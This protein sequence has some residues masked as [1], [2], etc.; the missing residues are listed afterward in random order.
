MTDGTEKPLERNVRTVCDLV[1]SSLGPF[2]TN[3]LVVEADGTVTT[4]SSGSEIVERLD[5]TNPT[6]S[7]LETAVADFSEQRGDGAATVVTLL[8][9]LL[10]EADR[11]TDQGCHPTIVERGYREALD[12]VNEYLDRHARPL[13]EFGTDAVARTALTGTRDPN[14]RAMVAEY[15]ADIVDDVT[16]SDRESVGRSVKVTSRIGGAQAET[17]L[18]SG[19]VLDLD[20]ASQTMP[21]SVE[22]GGV[23]VLSTTVDV[24]NVGATGS[25][26]ERRIRADSFETRDAIG[27]HERT[28]FRET[29][30]AAVDAGCRV[31]FTSMAVNERV[32]NRLA[33]RGI[34]A[35]PH[36]DEDD[37]GKIA[38]TTGATVIPSLDDVTAET[39]GA[40]DVNVRRHAGTDMVHVEGGTNPVYTLFC[41]APDPHAADE[42]EASV[43]R[44]LYAAASARDSDTVVPGGGAVAI[45]AAQAVKEYGRSVSGREQ[46]AV[47]AFADALTTVPRAL[48]QNGGMDGWEALVQLVVAHNEGRDAY[49]VDSVLGETRDVLSDDPLV[50]PTEQT[51]AAFTA[52]TDLAVRL[53]RIDEQVA[54]SDLGGDE[55]GVADA[56]VS[57]PGAGTR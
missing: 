12:V 1:E 21:R 22:R 19:V 46:L 43:E 36:V 32:V 23:A 47:T 52:A 20:P 13:G 38:R 31:I 33:N 53:V 14:T 9:G 56:G 48:A 41:R 15:I 6:V 50:D 29:L 45:G 4:T 51:R 30:S 11:L 35:V 24:P 18:V 49:G 3:K 44:A 16:D 34:L 57:G 55:N 37:L 54:A 27:E 5:V 17:Q 28:Q 39:L 25:T 2:G 26:S 42:F 40:G 8:G 10:R 7:L